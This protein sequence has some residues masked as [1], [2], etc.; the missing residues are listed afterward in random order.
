MASSRPGPYDPALVPYL[1]EI[2]D[3]IRPVTPTTPLA[4]RPRLVVL[5]KGTQIGA[6][7]AALNIWLYHALTNPGPD[8][9]ML[10]SVEL[11]RRLS[12]DKIQP[13]IDYSDALRAII[14]EKT[15]EIRYKKYPDGSLR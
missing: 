8:A 5:V 6:T 2:V 1:R 11:A 3:S 4:N 15:S 10:P 9:I 13:M 12:K 7:D 14:S